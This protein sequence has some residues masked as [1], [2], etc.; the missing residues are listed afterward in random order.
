MDGWHGTARRFDVPDPF[1]TGMD[2]GFHVALGSPAAANERLGYPATFEAKLSTFLAELLG[3]EN[4]FTRAD[5]KAKP[6]AVMPLALRVTN[7]LRLPDMGSWEN[8]L[9]Y[10][11]SEAANLLP[12]WLK[13]WAHDWINRTGS[14]NEANAQMY[15]HTHEFGRA[16]TAELERRGYDAVIYKNAAE[17]KGKDKIGRAHV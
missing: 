2:L 11:D 5:L 16:L 17:A 14:H 10:R 1:R 6:A 3:K 9:T 8:P 4:H 15:G 7:P 12:G 13:Y